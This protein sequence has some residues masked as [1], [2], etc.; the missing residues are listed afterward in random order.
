MDQNVEVPVVF[1][2]IHSGSTGK[3]SQAT[4]DLQMKVLNDSFSGATSGAPSPY[5]FLLKKVTF[6]DD[7]NWYE[8]CGSG[9]VE[10]AI[11]TL[12]EGGPETLNV[13]SC[14]PDG[15]L[16]GWATFPNWYGS[17]PK[18]DGVVILDDSLPGGSANNYN[19]GDTLTHEVG[20]WLGLY[21]T[22]QGGCNGSGDYVSDTPAERSPA[23]GCPTGSDS[24]RRD[25]GL[26]PIRNF[27]DYTY[28]SCMYEFTGGQVV[29]AY[30]QSSLYR[31]LGTVT[32]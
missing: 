4:I 1:H 12:R 2:V 25:P 17:N 13:Y 8:N 29:R 14:R 11:K 3:I 10:A 6:T 31:G 16:L 18:D 19:L 15:G 32:P 22:F 9:S 5:T 30:E 23:Y 20:H 7:R 24:C 21:H 28:D 27:M 26:D